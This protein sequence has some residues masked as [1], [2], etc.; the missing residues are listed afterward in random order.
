MSKLAVFDFDSTIIDG[1][2]GDFMETDEFNLP[3]HL[4][5]LYTQ[6][7]WP[8]RMNAA[9]DLINKKLSF[10]S[11]KVLE[12]VRLIKISDSMC[13][14]IKKLKKQNFTLLI[15]SDG[16]SIFIETIL[17]ENSLLD[18]FDRIITNKASVSNGLIQIMPYFDQIKSLKPCDL[19][20]KLCGKPSICKQTILKDYIKNNKNF[21]KLIYIA[22][23]ENDYC[24][25]LCLDES[26]N[27]F[28]RRNFALHKLIEKN[29]REVKS[30]V[31][32][33]DDANDI[34]SYLD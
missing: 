20:M 6:F 4:E 24:A 10:N 32:Y 27:S 11:E 18:Y 19:C 22:D 15:I 1:D 17:A 23:G 25:V 26:S 29:L 2:S 34:S 31:I 21:E 28:A 30:K 12:K 33:W 3:N 9:F 14:L 5:D 16:N 13:N 7:N 8:I